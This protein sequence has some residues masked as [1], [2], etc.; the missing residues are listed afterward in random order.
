[1][2]QLKINVLCN[3]L[4]KSTAIFCIF[5][6]KRT[7]TFDDFLHKKGAI[8]AK[9]CHRVRGVLSISVTELGVCCRP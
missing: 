9:T 7:A 4:H 6:H 1:L 3:A 5:K 2:K 8:F